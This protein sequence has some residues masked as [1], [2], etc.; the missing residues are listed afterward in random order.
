MSKTEKNILYWSN[1]KKRYEG[2][3][4]DGKLNGLETEWY[5]NGQKS[6]EGTYKDGQL[7]S[8]E[9]WDENGNNQNCY[10]MPMGGEPFIENINLP[11]TKYL[12]ENGV[13][14]VDTR[15]EEL[16]IEGHIKNALNSD[17]F[18][19]LIFKIESLQTKDVAVVIYCGDD[20]CGSSE[21][22]AYDLSDEGFT[23]LFILWGGL[24]AWNEAGYP[25]ENQ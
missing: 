12:F 19:E 13:V 1:G 16:F 8:E 2:T 25:T 4:K 7:I 18:E 5:E 24:E 10:E 6:R 9:C 20:E 22:L 17:S 14:F 15:T 11:H 23:K 3:W 21:E